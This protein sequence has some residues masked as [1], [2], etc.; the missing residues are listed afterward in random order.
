M[1]RDEKFNSIRCRCD[2]LYPVPTRKNGVRIFDIWKVVSNCVISIK[3]GGFTAKLFHEK[4]EVATY[5]LG[6][7]SQFV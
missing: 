2:E 4:H 1:S 3:N 6:T 7:I 5:N